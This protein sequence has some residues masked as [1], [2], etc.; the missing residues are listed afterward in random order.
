[1]S[2]KSK[3]NEV[4]L[5]W[6]AIIEQFL[7]DNG[8]DPMRISGIK[9]G[10]SVNYGLAMPTL[11]EDGDEMVLRFEVSCIRK[12]NDP[13]AMAEEYQQILEDEKEMKE[14][15]KAAREARKNVELV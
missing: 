6:L 14:L 2:L 5:K 9:S 7:K 13:Y 1:M 12:N 15:K 3:E 4:R 11:T 10:S 8:E